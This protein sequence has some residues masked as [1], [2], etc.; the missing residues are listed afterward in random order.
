MPLLFTPGPFLGVLW[1]VDRERFR[2]PRFYGPV[3][4][5]PEVSPLS[6]PSAKK[7]PLSRLS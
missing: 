1:Q 4:V 6:K 5:Q 7:G 2:M 3:A